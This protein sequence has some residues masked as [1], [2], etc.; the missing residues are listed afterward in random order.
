[1]P[2]TRLFFAPTHW[3][4]AGLALALLMP[5]ASQAQYK[6]VGPDGKITY[7][8]RPPP[9]AQG[10]AQAMDAGGADAASTTALASLPFE[11]RQIATRYPV[12]LYTLAGCTDCDS[13]RQL[14]KQRGI[15]YAEKVAGPN[16]GDA[17]QKATGGRELPVL[18]IGSQVL[19]GY[20]SN[21]WTSYL[22]AAGY[23]KTSG[24]PTN[25]P[26]PAP[27]PLVVAPKA[28]VAKAPSPTTAPTPA[29]PPPAPGG[30]RF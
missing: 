23:P 29:A 20:S 7:T 4:L 13:G 24:L 15:P 26:A 8:D 3:A 9:A 22:D 19:R 1:M 10:K 14:L 28:A 5:M 11:L 17:L 30:I 16:D 6:V 2:H 18:T 21:N 25:Y 27:A 12:T